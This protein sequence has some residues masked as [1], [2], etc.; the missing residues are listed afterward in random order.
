MIGSGSLKHNLDAIDEVRSLL[1]GLRTD[2]FNELLDKLP[3]FVVCGPQSAGKSSLIRRISGVSLPTSSSACT[4]MATTVSV[5]RDAI[6]SVRVEMLGPG[7]SCETFFST[8]DTQFDK[9][10][11]ND[12]V[13][14]AQEK[15]IE[16]SGKKFVTD[17]ETKVSVS[18]PS[19]CNVTLIDLPGFHT[20]NDSDT[21]IV[22]TMVRLFFFFCNNG[23]VPM[24]LLLSTG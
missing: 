18:G 4:R 11:L 10:K 19:L 3:Q 23:G 9:T 21:K 15:A 20:K 8:S 13:A 17:Y 7:G 22:N 5:R 16:L 12:A 24:H 2:V 1:S 6:D 14:N